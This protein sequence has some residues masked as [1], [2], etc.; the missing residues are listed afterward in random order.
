M[1]QYPQY[2]EKTSYYIKDKSFFPHSFHKFDDSEICFSTS[3]LDWDNNDKLYDKDIDYYYVSFFSPHS[4]V[5]EYEKGKETYFS[6]EMDRHLNPIKLSITDRNKRWTVY[7][8]EYREYNE[9]YWEQEKESFNSIEELRFFLNNDDSEL[10]K[11]FREYDCLELFDRSCEFILNQ[12][13][14][15]KEELENGTIMALVLL[16]KYE[17]SLDKTYRVKKEHISNA[18]R[19]INCSETLKTILKEFDIEEITDKQELDSYTISYKVIDNFARDVKYDEEN[20]ENFITKLED[21]NEDPYF[22]LY[23]NYEKFIN[24]SFF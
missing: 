6:F 14:K 8:P 19:Y 15:M 12:K 21:L 17:L 11:K 7:E 9:W 18:T 4:Y 1:K 10:S 13:S 16:S 22:T 5:E 20:I 2:Y 3:K 24:N 23:I